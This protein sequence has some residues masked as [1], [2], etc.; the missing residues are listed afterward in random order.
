M[1][2]NEQIIQ[3]EYVGKENTLPKT[4]TLES[5]EKLSI[6]LDAL[7]E[8][9]N[10][11]DEDKLSVEQKSKFLKVKEKIFNFSKNFVRGMEYVTMVITIF[12]VVNYERTHSGLEKNLKKNGEITYSHED[13]RTTHLLNVFAGIEKF[14]EED[15]LVDIRPLLER[16]LKNFN[17]STEK[18]VGDMSLDEIDEFLFKNR[19]VIN[20]ND[21]TDTT[22][23]GDF[24]KTFE[25]KLESMNSKIDFTKKT[26]EN[27]YKLVWGLEEECGNPKIRFNNEGANFT[28]FKPFKGESHYNPINNT[29]FID[30]HDLT[31]I[32]V[33]E[34]F[35][36]MSHAKQFNENEIG[37]FLKVCSDCISIVK[38]SGFNPKKMAG[39]YMKLYH[40]PGSIEYEAHHNIEKDLREKYKILLSKNIKHE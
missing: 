1:K 3:K 18:D 7:K 4:D 29:I 24:K 17:L 12:A 16:T 37:T 11:I 5:A 33:G 25:T 34:F 22:K 35:P 31:N 13:E 30:P 15:L 38:N 8:E 36:E 39:E 20:P 19:K 23:L 26:N 14:N 6:D 32:Q 10:S 28:P 21:D 2:N 40:K 9:I 27:L